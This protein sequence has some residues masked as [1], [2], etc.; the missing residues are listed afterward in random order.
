[1]APNSMRMYYSTSTDSSRLISKFR[2]PSRNEWIS[3]DG[4]KRKGRREHDQQ[5]SA[6]PTPEILFRLSGINNKAC[7]Y[8]VEAQQQQGQRGGRDQMQCGHATLGK[9]NSGSCKI[10]YALLAAERSPY[11]TWMSGLPTIMRAGRTAENREKS[12]GVG[13]METRLS[14]STQNTHCQSF[15]PLLR[16]L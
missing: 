5:C 12:V 4:E 10:K 14:W 9:I 3:Y 11:T 1:M 8:N 7:I 13:R 16:S 15:C 2:S 6:R